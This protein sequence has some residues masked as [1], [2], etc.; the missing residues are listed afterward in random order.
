MAASKT[1][2]KDGQQMPP[3]PAGF[4]RPWPVS[5][6]SDFFLYLSP[7]RLFGFLALLRRRSLICRAPKTT[8]VSYARSAARN[9][10][11]P[12]NSSRESL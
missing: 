12:L 9:S 2:R 4:R 1:T 10:R 3:Q 8:L 11:L 7:V 5:F 6:F